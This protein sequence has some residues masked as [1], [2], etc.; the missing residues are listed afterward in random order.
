MQSI[1]SAQDIGCLQQRLL[2]LKNYL[3]YT[4]NDNKKERVS[5]DAFALYCL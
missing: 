2:D 3:G 5:S 1:V 4:I